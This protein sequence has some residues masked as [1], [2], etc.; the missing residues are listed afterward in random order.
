M[1]GSDEPRVSVRVS[2]GRI[3]H[4]GKG[5]PAPPLDIEEAI[6]A[7]PDG[8]PVEVGVRTIRVVRPGMGKSG[9]VRVIH[10][11]IARDATPRERRTYEEST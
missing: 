2:P 8:T 4:G 1:R 9:G 11:Y 5:S 7:N 10:Y 3:R 6:S